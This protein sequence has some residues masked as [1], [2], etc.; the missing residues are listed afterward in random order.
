[1][2][3]LIT[4]VILLIPTGD[5]V[6]GRETYHLIID[7]KAYEHVYIEEVKN[8]YKTGIFVYNEDLEN[9]GD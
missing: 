3:E 9:E 2:F 1:M 5:N 8:F 7:N 6:D 4:S